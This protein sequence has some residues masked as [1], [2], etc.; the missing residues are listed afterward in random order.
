MMEWD[1]FLASLVIIPGVD[2]GG[3]DDDDDDV[4]GGGE[5]VTETKEVWWRCS[6]L[7]YLVSCRFI[8]MGRQ[9]VNVVKML[10]EI[11]CIF[12]TRSFTTI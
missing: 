10:F 9:R 8:G 7:A 11:N 1:Q 12:N 3:G 2:I 5:T 4:M 6:L